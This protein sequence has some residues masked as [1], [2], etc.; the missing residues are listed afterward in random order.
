MRLL[1]TVD[2][3]GGVWRYALDAARGLQQQGVECML[4]G[5]GPPPDAARR[6]AC[7]R[8]HGVRLVWTDVPL[9][10]MVD[11]EAALAPVGAAIDDLVARWRP[12]VL[13]LNLPSQAAGLRTDLPVVVAA[14]SCVPTWWAQVR[15]GDLPDAWRW[16][17]GCNRRGFARADVVLVPS[18]S[19]GDALRRA[20]GPLD[21]LRVVFNTTSAALC[22]RPKE[23]FVV[24]AG[25]WW[26]EGKN[27]ALLDA[28]AAAAEW[29]V[30]MAGPLRGPA[31]VEWRPRHADAPGEL[32]AD[33]VLALMRRAAVFAAPSRYEPFGLAVLEAACSGCALLLSDIPTFNELWADAAIFAS[34]DDP[35]AWTLALRDLAA[36]PAR[37]TQLGAAARA[38]AASLVARS[39]GAALCDAYAACKVGAA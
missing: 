8:L 18:A 38:R 19:H 31:G 14:H 17:L 1:M 26:D 36:D 30:V 11:E 34:A 6:A 32:S 23:P 24:A 4:A 7:E 15:G 35:A 10:W 3:V 22:L 37:C 28:V 5:F 39:Q 12:D 33:D 2:A 9:D 29:P 27:G 13:H 25:R 16:Q 20:Y 21:R